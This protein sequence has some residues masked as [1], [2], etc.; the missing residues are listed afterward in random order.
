MSNLTKQFQKLYS[1][2]GKQLFIVFGIFVIAY[3]LRILFLKDNALSFTFDQAR[4]AFVIQ[5]ILRGD[6]KILG[7]SVSGV[8]GL[9]HGVLYYYLIA[10]AYYFGH[11]DP[12]VVAYFLS[13]L[14]SL[15]VFTVFY[16]TYLLTKKYTPAVISAAV[17]AFSFEATQYS[18]LLTNA[19]M[20]VWFVPI[21]YIG[22]YLWTHRS[23]RWSPLIT[24]LFF[25]LS[26]QSEIALFYH[27]V[28]IIIWLTFFRKKLEMKQ[29]VAF[30]LSFIVAVST[31]ILAEFKFGFSGISGIIYL[32]T[33]RDGIVQT[34]QFS[35]YLI[36]AINQ[37]GK[38]FAYTIFPSNVVFGGLLGFIMVTIVLW[39]KSFWG[40]FLSSYIF[41]Y[42]IALPFGGWNMKHILVGTAPA[43]SVLVGIFIWNYT[44]KSKI[45]MCLILLIVFGTN[46]LKIVQVNR[47]GQVLFLPSDMSLSSELKVISYTYDNSNSKPFSISTLTNPLFVNVVWSY[48]Y[49]QYGV[50]KYGYLPYWVGQDQ[51][52]QLG[53]NLLPPS[54]NTNNHFFIIEPTTGIPELWINY[55]KGDQESISTLVEQKDF[56][57]LQVQK[58]ILKN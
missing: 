25:G 51:I 8:P 49:N 11:G 34:K 22:L 30:L 55:A 9:Y 57:S 56:G 15:G 24:G 54:K 46:L 32:L 52:G 47:Q 45:L 35:D 37:T 43:I 13:F 29:I 28:P 48:L 58:R 31:M 20:G 17:F 18:N 7:P 27:I 38:T 26:V 19:S 1:S 10:P 14:S 36:T 44:S 33:S 21:I 53:N 6:L 12:I 5:N 41:A 42:L 23:S 2:T 4:D 39:N 16:F 50:K 40:K 3:I